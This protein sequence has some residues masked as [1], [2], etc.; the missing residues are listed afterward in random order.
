[1]PMDRAYCLLTVKDV[2]EDDRIITGIATTPSPDRMGDIIE[3]LGVKFTNPMPLL[4]QHN[5]RNPVG[6]VIFDKPTKAG[7]TFRAK[8]PKIDE[9]GSLKDR[10]DTAWG[11]VK[12]GLVRGV[13]IG[14]APLEYSRM[15]GGGLRFLECEVLELSLVTVPANADAQIQTIKSLDREALAASG[16]ERVPVER[17]ETP[18]ASGTKALSTTKTTTQSR[19]ATMPK[20]IAEQIAAFEAKRAAHTARLGEIMAKSGEELTTLDEADSTESDELTGEI[21]AIDKHLVRLRHLEKVVVEKATAVAGKTSDEAAATRASV[22]V[23]VKNKDV[24]KGTAFTRFAMAL[25][26]SKGNLLQAERIAKTWE[27]STP[28]VAVILKAAVDAGTTTDTDWAKPLVQ[29]TNMASE[30]I[31]FLRPQT[32]VG[33]IPGL[34]R[35][36][37]NINIPRQT[38]ASSAGWVGE[39]KPKPV[40]ALAFD[41][42]S[43]GMAKIAGIVVMT[44]ELVRSSNPAAEGI[45]RQDL[46]DTIIQTMDK[47]FVDPAKAAVN[48]VSPAS[49]TNGVTPIVASGITADHVRADV[50]KLFN[51]F[52]TAN[53]SLAGAVFIMKETTALS[54]SL[55][56]NPLGQPEFPGIQT[57]GGGTFFGLPLITSENIPANAGSGSPIT[58]NGDRIILAKATEILLADDGQVMLDSSN[59]ASLQMDSA[60][61]DPPVAATVMVSL[62]QMN[63]VGIRAE[64]YINWAKRRPGAVQYIDQVKYQG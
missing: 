37:F 27:D 18:A 11:E 41:Q 42:I 46:A 50:Q 24:P 1:M 59:Q 34:R 19:R 31:E 44:D 16:R 15:E 39:G 47:D 4:H 45:V 21:E 36:P 10:V 54:L 48:N 58:G 43:L 64:R 55:M 7:I 33:R 57:S 49:I 30:F 13:S 60:P 52:I 56:L 62:W 29:Y 3:P 2:S 28:E 20:T 23:E 51:A 17:R 22:R 35:V 53:L 26:Q 38:G 63:L 32:I 6:T 5:H 40:G 25:M 9:A 12:A 61:T 8:L 14:F